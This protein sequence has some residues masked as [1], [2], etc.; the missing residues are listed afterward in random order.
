[1][2][3]SGSVVDESFSYSEL[4]PNTTYT[5]RV[6]GA[7]SIGTGPFTNDTYFSTAGKYTT[8]VDLSLYIDFH[9]NVATLLFHSRTIT[10]C[11]LNCIQLYKSQ[12]ILD[13]A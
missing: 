8:I 9:D 12:H 11:H 4:I 1:M 6:A 13:S 3:I 5:F 7:N 2:L 10:S